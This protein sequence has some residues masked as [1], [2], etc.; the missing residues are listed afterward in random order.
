MQSTSDLLSALSGAGVTVSL[1]GDKLK[2]VPGKLV[3]EAVKQVIVQHKREIIESLR[4]AAVTH[5]GEEGNPWDWLRPISEGKP[6]Y[7]GRGQGPSCFSCQ[8]YDGKG[9]SWPG[10]CRF[11]ESIGRVVLELDWNIVDIVNGCGCYETDVKRIAIR[12]AEPDFC[13]DDSPFEESGSPSCD[14]QPVTAHPSC[15]EKI[16]PVALKWLREHHQELKAAGWTMRELYRRNRS[17]GLA[18]ARVWDKAG[19]VATMREGVLAIEF[20]DGGKVV[21]QTARPT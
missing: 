20:Q 18:W 4:L 6:C 14:Q 7:A 3:T 8:S 11:P 21:R 12:D 13:F 19:M 5:P 9:A 15:R 17:R 2:V 10:L 16:S 1:V